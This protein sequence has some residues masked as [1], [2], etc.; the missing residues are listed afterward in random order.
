MVKVAVPLA[1]F[2]LL[3]FPAVADYVVYH[4]K[5]AYENGGHGAIDIDSDGT[6]PAGL[7]VADCEACCDGDA[8]CDCVTFRPSDGKCWKRTACVPAKF[9][10]DG[11]FDTY[12]KPGHSSCSPELCGD[13]AGTVTLAEKTYYIDRQIN[14][15]DGVEILGAG[16]NKTFIRALGN[17][18]PRGARFI[19]GHHTK[20]G[21]FTFAGNDG[22]RNYFGSPVEP[23]G[24]INR[25]AN[26]QCG[27]QCTGVGNS[28]DGISHALV[29]DI[30]IEAKT[31]T[32]AVWV[33]ITP[34]GSS[35]SSDI[36]YD[37]IRARHLFADGVN[38]HGGHKRITVQNCVLDNT[39]DD[40][41]AI[42]NGKVGGQG[43]E[44][45]TEDI[46]FINN[47]VINPVYRKDGHEDGTP[48]PVCCYA[49]FGGGSRFVLKGNRCLQ[50]SNAD[51]LRVCGTRCEPAVPVDGSH[52]VLEGNSADD[53][54]QHLARFW[55]SWQAGHAVDIACDGT[56]DVA[57]QTAQQVVFSYDASKGGEQ[58]SWSGTDRSSKLST[59]DLEQPGRVLV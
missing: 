58:A 11:S 39:G 14:L 13:L 46:S 15:P 19:L 4:G 45:E 52:V 18:Q 38:V 31:T 25:G 6:A 40:G 57:T 5:N 37:N 10:A 44:A 23:P 48:G 50:S 43:S 54:L 16:I 3:G 53:S 20:I 42:W 34:E 55:P 17:M 30:E 2:A 51:F 59:P 32:N 33:S 12:A 36:M 29:H 35:V 28:C 9:G 1:T 8:A 56:C 7:S 47:T 26:A 49:L 27:D 22:S 41:M 21:G 24:C